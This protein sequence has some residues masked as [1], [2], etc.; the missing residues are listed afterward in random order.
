M[1]A[2][3]DKEI[4][5]IGGGPGGLTLARL[6]QMNGADVK[7]YVTLADMYGCREQRLIF[8]RIQD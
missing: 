7:V 5:I 3:K 8:M 4:A 6:L 1:K 2:I